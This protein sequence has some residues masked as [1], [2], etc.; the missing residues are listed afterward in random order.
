MVEDNIF[1]ENC[2]LTITYPNYGKIGRNYGELFDY[3]GDYDIVNA[4]EI[5]ED[6]VI[7]SEYVF[8]FTHNDEK[9]LSEKSIVTLKEVGKLNDFIE[10]NNKTHLDFYNWYY[11]L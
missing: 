8:L 9:L 6:V 4:S 2:S 3:L 11:N 5:G 1:Y 10:L 7:M